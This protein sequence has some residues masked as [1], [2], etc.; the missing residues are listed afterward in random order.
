MVYNLEFI[1]FFF[2][3]FFTYLSERYNEI[4]KE[5]LRIEHKIMVFQSFDAF[6]T[7]FPLSF[8]DPYF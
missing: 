6:F 7:I 2:F 1:F 5:K 3:L 4:E 8:V